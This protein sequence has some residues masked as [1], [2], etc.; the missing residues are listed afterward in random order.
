MVQIAV[1]G[2][3]LPCSPPR[4]PSPHCMPWQALIH[5]FI[6]P[7]QLHPSTPAPQSPPTFPP[8]PCSY[9]SRR[10]FDTHAHASKAGARP[11][12]SL[13]LPVVNGH[14]G[15]TAAALTVTQTSASQS[16][17]P[18]ASDQRYKACLMTSATE[19]G[20]LLE[21]MRGTM[22]VTMPATTISIR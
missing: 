7:Q 19:G 8:C 10:A 11:S 15:A 5:A 13:V 16:S 18:C 14:V 17:C 9:I 20:S 3:A 12:S 6:F 2:P 1:C 4:H 21:R 22:P